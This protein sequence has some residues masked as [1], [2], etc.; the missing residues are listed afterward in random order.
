MA[1]LNATEL[2]LEGL[3]AETA[4]SSAQ[5]SPYPRWAVATS[6]WLPDWPWRKLFVESPNR[7]LLLIMAAGLLAT[8]FLLYGPSLANHTRTT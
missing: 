6:R 7:P 8:A 4:D 1:E 3:E 2:N 5:P